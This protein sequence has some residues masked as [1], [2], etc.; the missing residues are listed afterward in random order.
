MMMKAGIQAVTLDDTVPDGA[1]WHFVQNDPTAYYPHTFTPTAGTI[2]LPGT[3]AAAS[4]T[5]P[6]GV[7]DLWVQKRGAVDGL[8][9]AGGDAS[10]IAGGD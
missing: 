7:R 10:R 3:G 8:E 4:A 1:I 5:W 9:N 6:K 2:D